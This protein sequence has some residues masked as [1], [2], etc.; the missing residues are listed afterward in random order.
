MMRDL[1]NASNWADLF[2][3]DGFSMVMGALV[4]VAGLTAL[5][6]SD[7]FKRWRAEAQEHAKWMHWNRR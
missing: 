1:C 3:E 2:H 5:L 7:D 4:V 6:F